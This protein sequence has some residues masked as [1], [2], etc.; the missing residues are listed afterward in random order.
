MLDLSKTLR[1]FYSSL[2][3]NN[4]KLEDLKNEITRRAKEKGGVCDEYKR[5]LKSENKESLLKVVIDNF[6]WCYSRNVIDAWLL[7]CFGEKLVNQH[8]I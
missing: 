1:K 2:N 5:A 4:M 8:G 3:K 6:S 7:E